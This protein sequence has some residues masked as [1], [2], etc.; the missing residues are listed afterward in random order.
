M[1]GKVSAAPSRTK[2]IVVTVLA[3]LVLMLTGAGAHFAWR[4][5]RLPQRIEHDVGPA[6]DLS[7]SPGVLQERISKAQALLRDRATT[8]DGVAELGR[9]YHANSFRTAAEACWRVLRREDPREARWS[10]YLADLRRLASDYPE[11]TSLL[12]Q[13]VELAPD[14]APALLQLGE[15]EFKQGNPESAARLYRQ[16]LSVLPS[17]PY[18]KLGLARIAL[19]NQRRDEARQLLEEICREAPKFPSGHNLLAE[20]LAAES[21]EKSADRHR[22][23]GREAG[24]FREADDAW[25]NE[26]NEW[27]FDARRLRILATIAYQTGDAD[28]GLSLLLRA[29]ELAPENREGLETLGDLYLRLNKPAEAVDAL[30]RS[31]EVSDTAKPS[32]R[33]FVNLSQA[34]RNLKRLDEALA[35]TEQG[36]ARVGEAF[37]IHDAKGV[38][39]AELGRREEAVAAFEDA[40]ALRPNDANSNFNLALNLLALNRVDE[41]Y[42]KLKQSLTLEPTFAKSLT[43]LTEMEMESGRLDAAEEFARQLY[44][45]QPG[46][47]RAKQLLGLLYLR[48]GTTAQEKGDVI[49]AE[50]HYRDTTEVDPEGPEAHVS[51]GVLLLLQQRFQE[52]ITPLEAYRRLQPDRPQSSLYLGQVYASVGRVPEARRILQEGIKIAERTGN[53]KTAQNCR[54]ILE[55]L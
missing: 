25:L 47:P 28:K 53:T 31:L 27:C 36:L 34:L 54:M 26:L 20:I 46:M 12:T 3:A 21:D 51:L 55:Q 7:K 23:L 2:I 11:L 39:L 44:D 32:P 22:W 50:K 49:K 19:G 41:A 35:A 5:Y 45:A 42:G 30:N 17:D 4:W 8:L 52:A 48:A 15:I 9:L 6:P 14:Y 16:R 43:L 13:T 37:E 29:I 18:A 38:A 33:T 10:Y 40:L 1:P 24:R